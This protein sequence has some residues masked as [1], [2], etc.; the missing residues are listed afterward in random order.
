MCLLRTQFCHQ[1]ELRGLV[2]GNAVHTAMPR[3]TR[4]L[5]AI[6]GIGSAKAASLAR[7]YLLHISHQILRPHRQRER[8]A[9]LDEY[10]YRFTLDVM[11]E[12]FQTLMNW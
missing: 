2:D 9:E 7:V 12:Q 3:L 5:L 10:M 6:R 1:N 4:L 8:D 11:R